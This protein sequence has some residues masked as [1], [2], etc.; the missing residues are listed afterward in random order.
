MRGSINS[1]FADLVYTLILNIIIKIIIVII[2]KVLIIILL[3][4]H[5]RLMEFYLFSCFCQQVLFA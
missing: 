5:L 2:I 1:P 4:F 3:P